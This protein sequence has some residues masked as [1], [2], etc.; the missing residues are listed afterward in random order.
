MQLLRHSV[1]GLTRYNQTYD[2]PLMQH[3]KL[4]IAYCCRV[5]HYNIFDCLNN[6]IV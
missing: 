6:P 1:L 2:K 4:E 5:E 3:S